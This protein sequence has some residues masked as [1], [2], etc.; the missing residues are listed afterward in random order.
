MRYF[1]TC[2]TWHVFIMSI[3]LNRW[4]INKSESRAKSIYP[5]KLPRRSCGS[6]KCILGLVVS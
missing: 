6:T 2:L 1:F 3:S 5:K 4:N